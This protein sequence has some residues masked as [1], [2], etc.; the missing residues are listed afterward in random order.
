MSRE[1]RA[2]TSLREIC[3]AFGQGEKT[4]KAWAAAGA[5]I[6]VWGTGNRR[7]YMTD[8]STAV[9]KIT[10]PLFFSGLGD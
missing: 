4:V 3:Q 1:F 8:L 5:P 9:E 2:L 6:R 7:R 10:T